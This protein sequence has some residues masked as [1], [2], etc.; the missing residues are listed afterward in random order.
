[1]YAVVD[2]GGKQAKV[3]KD[4]V[5][6]VERI[7][8]DVGGKVTLPVLFL[9]DG[10]KILATPDELAGVT[11]SAEVLEHFKGD[12]QM[13]FKLKKR[14]GY[15]RTKGHRQTLTAVRILDITVGEAPAKVAKP[16]KAAE[17]K[18]PEEKVEAP[19]KAAAPKEKLAKDKP[20][21]DKPA[22]PETADVV[23]EPTKKAAAAEPAEAAQCEAIKSDGTRCA[24]KAKEGSKYCGVHAKKYEG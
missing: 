2:T 11:V 15:K 6:A 9:A 8:A 21:K 1:M 4:S 13:V 7:K 17:A 24:N 16:A 23:A 3:E 22:K 5:I 19:A 18:A 20:A 10:E 14:K 12:K